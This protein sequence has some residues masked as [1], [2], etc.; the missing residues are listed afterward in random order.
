MMYNRLFLMEH[1]CH[2]IP[3]EMPPGTGIYALNTHA[4]RLL[5]IDK[6][7]GGGLGGGGGVY[8]WINQNTSEKFSAN[9]SIALKS[10]KAVTAHLESEQL[11]YFGFAW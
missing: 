11:L 7:S 1:N 9:V 2:D 6:Y 5:T 10:Q 3:I 4:D 8:Q